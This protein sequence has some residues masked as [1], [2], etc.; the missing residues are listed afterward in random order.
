[1]VVEQGHDDGA[2]AKSGT[3]A[4]ERALRVGIDVARQQRAEGPLLDFMQEEIINV[5]RLN[6]N[7]FFCISGSLPLF[8]MDNPV[9]TSVH[10]FRS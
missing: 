9:D 10:S 4:T 2:L 5:R 7:L 6:H 8:V 1:M 3:D